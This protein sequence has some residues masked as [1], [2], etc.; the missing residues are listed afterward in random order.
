MLIT[1]LG[2]L[3]L[4]Q[5]GD[6]HF[7]RLFASSGVFK[8]QPVLAATT[9]GKFCHCASVWQPVPSFCARCMGLAPMILR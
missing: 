2:H 4:F 6:C 8:H 9:G 3:R 5:P 1:E 7:G